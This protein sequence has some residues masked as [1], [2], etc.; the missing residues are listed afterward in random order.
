MIVPAPSGLYKS[1]SLE[2]S[3]CDPDWNEIFYYY[4]R[5]MEYMAEWNDTILVNIWD[6]VIDA[7]VI[8]AK[9][10]TY[11]LFT[12]AVCTEDEGIPTQLATY[13]Y[14]KPEILT[15]INIQNGELSINQDM[16]WPV[17]I[18]L[19]NLTNNTS[20]EI[21]LNQSFKQWET[22]NAFQYFDITQLDGKNCC[23]IVQDGSGQTVFEEKFYKL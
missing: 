11:S 5:P 6:H 21:S 22:L 17:R 10:G 23:L 14:H 4:Y 8:P 13:D 12:K 16:Q 1:L 3:V 18:V 19:M 7:S 15:Q 9:E 20:Q 2:F